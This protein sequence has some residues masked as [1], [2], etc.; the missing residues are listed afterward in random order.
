MGE[1]CLLIT[2]IMIK[3]GLLSSLSIF[4]IILNIIRMRFMGPREATEASKQMLPMQTF[5]KL[6]MTIFFSKH[7]PMWILSPLFP[8]VESNPLCF[9]P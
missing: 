5:K 1:L 9:D 7:W 2:D 8:Q 3:I 6:I 4:A